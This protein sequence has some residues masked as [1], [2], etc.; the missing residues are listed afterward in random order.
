MNWA[1]FA[2]AVSAALV[3]TWIYLTTKRNWSWPGLVASIG[4]L[5]VAAFNSAAP[6]RGLIDPNY[7]GY[8]FGLLH[9]EKGITVTL[10]AGPLL[11]FGALSALLA[12]SKKSGSA[13]WL[14]ATFCAALLVILGIPAVQGMLT[15]PEANAI[16]F[17]EFLTI[18]GLLATAIYMLLLVVPFLIGLL[19]APRAAMRSDD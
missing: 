4:C 19:W 14:V 12:V 15:S 5:L 18:P 17:G 10:L 1:L 2:L 3:A 13:L 11:L 7:V 6:F 16:Q 8:G 9:A